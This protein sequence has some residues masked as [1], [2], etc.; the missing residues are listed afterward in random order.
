[1]TDEHVLEMHLQQSTLALL[2]N[3]IKLT[4]TQW[5]Q[6]IRDYRYSFFCWILLIK[7][8]KHI[9][10]ICIFNFWTL[11]RMTV[12]GIIAI[13][14]FDQFRIIW[15]KLPDK[16]ADFVEIIAASMTECIGS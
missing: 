5:F 3:M 7:H 11:T 13:S 2:E 9:R 10:E 8:V 14:L 16:S 1:M 4:Y 15:I 6:N 12:D